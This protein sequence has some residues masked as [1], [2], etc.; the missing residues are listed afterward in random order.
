MIRVTVELVSARGADR[1]RLLG[2]A[3]IANDGGVVSEGRLLP[4]KFNYKVWLSKTLPGK[5]GQ[6]W[7]GGRLESIPEELEHVM[8]PDTGLQTEVRCFD[9]VKRGVWDLLYLGLKAVV[10][11]RNP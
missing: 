8:Q 10:A 7:K 2:V 5:T 3:Y 4:T 11:G 9:N 1:D 6:L